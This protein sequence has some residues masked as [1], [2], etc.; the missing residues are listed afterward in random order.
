MRQ[1]IQCPQCDGKN[2]SVVSQST[3]TT[4]NTAFRGIV[5]KCTDYRTTFVQC[6]RPRKQQNE[7]HVQ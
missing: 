7:A 4:S 5:L 3:S 1:P 6:S 2:L